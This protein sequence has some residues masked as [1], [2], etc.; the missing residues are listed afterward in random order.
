MAVS[1]VMRITF[2]LSHQKFDST[3]YLL[4]NLN[5]SHI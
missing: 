4:T 3:H 5:F 2:S 1:F